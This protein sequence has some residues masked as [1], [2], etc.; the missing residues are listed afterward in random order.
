VCWSSNQFATGTVAW[1][2]VLRVYN[3]WKMHFCTHDWAI[4]NPPR[5]TIQ[6]DWNVGIGTTTPDV[7]LQ[8]V[9]D[10]RFWEDTTNYSEFEADGTYVAHLDARVYKNEWVTV[11]WLKV[12]WTKP[13]TYTDWWINWWWEFSNWTDD[14]VVTTI[15][16]PQDMDKTVAPEF[17]IWFASDTNTWDVVWQLEYLYVT[18]N[19]DTTASA[20]ETLTTTQ[21][22]SS[23]A[24]WLTIATITWMDLPSATDQLL[25]LRLKRLGADAADT[26][27]DDCTL[28]GCW[29]KYVSDKFGVAL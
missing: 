22:I 2:S 10:A 25:I 9:W 11:S 24:D 5:I 15:R 1:D 14:T 4:S 13:A 3:G 29:L 7:K 6:Q 26:L 21:T 8:V 18:A 12:P 19:E 27:A 20:Q 28:V 23:T 16:I 17:K